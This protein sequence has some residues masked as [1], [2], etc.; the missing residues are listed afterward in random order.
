MLPNTSSKPLNT[1]LYSHLTAPYSL[2][3]TV[4]QPH[5][6]LLQQ[7]QVKKKEK[8]NKKKKKKKQK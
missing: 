6:S 4:P 8:K 1:Q 5:T 2:G 7:T 3:V